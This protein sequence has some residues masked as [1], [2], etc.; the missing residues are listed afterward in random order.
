MAD[1]Q[2]QAQPQVQGQGQGPPQDPAVI[3]FRNMTAEIAQLNQAFTTQGISSTV[4]RF[5]GNP[6]NYREWIKSIEK[7]ATLVNVPDNRKK[8][9]AYQSSAGAVSGF[10][11]RYML[12]NPNNTWG[13]LKEQL[14]VRFSD[15]T[16]AQ[17]ALSLLRAVKQ[18]PG[19]NIQVYAERILSLAEDAYQNQ[20]GDAIERQLI[21]IFVD[22][23]TNDQLKMKILRDQPATLQG[24]IAITTN[25]QN[26]RARVQ[27]SHNGPSYSHTRD[28]HAPME[29][30]H[31]RGQRFKYK[32]R[33]NR[34]NSTMN[35]Q[36]NRHVRCWHCGMLGH[37]SRD[38]K[39]K[40]Q[41]RPSMGHGR[42]RTANQMQQNH[43]EN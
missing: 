23:L 15:V 43:Q 11:Q 26:L 22:G 16:D 14:A 24:A 6:K 4:V 39:N 8:L 19:E 17:M 27:M 12:A 1:G 35:T 3:A 33:F 25:E 20:G 10:I 40:E 18:K 37:I 41:P 5:D 31:S 2:A 32:N 28:T 34:V 42:P 38:C 9:I 13:Q 7:Y 29:V 21:D 30:D 36:T